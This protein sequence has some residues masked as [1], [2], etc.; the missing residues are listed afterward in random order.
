MCEPTP[1]S[2]LPCT[3]I[4]A[5]TSHPHLGLTSASPAVPHAA[6]QLEA[7]EHA[8]QTLRAGR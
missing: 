7:L 3:L 4:L 5:L 6:K 1:I 8:R 2:D